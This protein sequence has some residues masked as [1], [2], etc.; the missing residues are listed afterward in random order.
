VATKKERA[1]AKS[2]VKF[3]LRKIDKATESLREY[4]EDAEKAYKAAHDEGDLKHSFNI[5]WSSC[6]I[7]RS[8]IYASRPKPDVRRRYQKPDPEEKELAR[9]V[10][11][12]IEYNLDVYDFESGSGNVV[13]DYVEVGLGVPRLVYEV[14]TQPLKNDLGEIIYLD[15][16][17]KDPAEEIV[18]QCVKV[19]HVPWSQFLWEPGKAWA[20]VEWLAFKT[21]KSRKDVADDY[22]VELKGGKDDE[23]KLKADEYEDLVTI[24]EIW[25]KPTKTIY[26]ICPNHPDAPLDEYPDELNL[27]TFFPVPQP[28]MANVKYDELIPK[29]DYCFV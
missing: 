27:S 12:A 20:D 22:G 1:Q 24:W 9:L 15:D 29:P 11:R 3:W 21:F 23:T 28:L 25:H 7:L 4:K 13:R 18:S 10:E 17:G 14:Q 2:S 8:A 6:A 5:H 16:K 19:E 26:V